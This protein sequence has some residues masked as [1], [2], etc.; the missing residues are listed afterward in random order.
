MLNELLVVERGL[1]H[2]GVPTVP[3]H[4]DVKD[5]GRV[6]ALLVDL[7]SAGF[8]ASVRPVPREAKPWTLRDG[9]QNS[10]PFVQLSA[11]VTEKQTLQVRPRAQWRRPPL[12]KVSEKDDGLRKRASDRRDSGRRQALL[13]LADRARFNVE[14]LERWPTQGFLDRLRER[15]EHVASLASASEAAVVPLTIDRFLLACGPAKSG[16]AMELLKTVATKLIEE[17]K[18][19]AQS[20]WLE[21]ATAILIG[22]FDKNKNRWESAGGLL[23]EADGPHASIVDRNLPA[24]VSRAIEEAES[25]VGSASMGTCGLTGARDVRLL[26]GSFPQPNLPVIGQTWLF[27]KNRDIPA[28]DRYGRFSAETMPVAQEVATRLAAAFTELTSPDRRGITW[29]AIPG[30]APKQ[31][32]L[33]LAFVDV[34]LDAPVA[35]ALAGED[36]SEEA[37]EEARA[38]DSVAAFEKRTERVIEAVKGRVGTD[39]RETPVRIAVFRK[40]DPA[41]RKV[42]YAGSPSVADLYGASKE[43]AD[44]ERNLP[45][46]LNILVLP[47]GERKPIARR[48]QHVAPLGLIAFSRQFFIRNGTER[49]EVVGVPAAEALALFLDATDSVGPSRRRVERLLRLLLARRTSLVSGIVHALRRPPD[50]RKKGSEDKFDLHEALRTVTLMGVLL[51]KLGRTKERYMNDAAFKLGQLLAAAD[52]VHAGYCADARGGGLPPSLLGNQFFTMALSAPAKALAMLSRRWKPYAG[53]A[54]KAAREP[55]RIAE[56]VASKKKDEERR[57]WDIRKALRQA[58]EVTPLAEELAQT[59]PSCVVDDTFRAEML[60]GYIAGLPKSERKTSEGATE[61]A[62]SAAEKE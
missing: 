59:L 42:V 26:S 44:G 60:L 4:P 35:D 2:A 13:D 5:V 37:Q 49:E 29:R 61:A 15:R 21:A 32:D 47:Q 41:N 62:E 22:K 50:P 7:D 3:L 18:Q 38:A 52:T 1:G 53:W 48:P 45:E 24:L 40:L 19:T 36:F 6:P 11:E 20:E 12:W 23:F 25:A 34:A 28:N 54:T 17:L 51:L 8:V 57:G 31:S 55:E 43:W 30:E 10:F 16:G 39:F 33:L 58:R 14:D 56:L 9:Q 27:S 46:W